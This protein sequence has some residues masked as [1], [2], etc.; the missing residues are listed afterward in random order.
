[1]IKVQK[2]IVINRPVE[3]VFA[4]IANPLNIPRWRPDVLEIRGTNGSI[5]ANSQFEELVSFMGKKVFPMQVIEYEPNRREVIKAI[6]GPGVRPTQS[7]QLEANE[8]GAT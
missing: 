5:Q 4:F 3:E 6:G 1:M 7:F 2:D 8:A